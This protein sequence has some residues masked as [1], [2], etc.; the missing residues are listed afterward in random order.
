MSLLPPQLTHSSISLT[1]LIATPSPTRSRSHDNVLRHCYLVEMSPSEALLT[2]FT[3]DTLTHKRSPTCRKALWPPF[4]NS[5]WQAATV[6]LSARN[7]CH[8]GGLRKPRVTVQM[9]LTIPRA[10]WSIAQWIAF[11]SGQQHLQISQVTETGPPPLTDSLPTVGNVI[12]N[13]G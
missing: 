2:S 12:T 6:C 10:G 1:A 5:C 7:A 11:Q 4:S 13:A 9:H 3:A 8:R